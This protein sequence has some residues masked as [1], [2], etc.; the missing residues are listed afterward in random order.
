MASDRRQAAHQHMEALREYASQH[1]TSIE[2][3]YGPYIA[4]SANAPTPLEYFRDIA[5]GH[6]YRYYVDRM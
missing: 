1:S 2:A 3:R 4:K 6:I 5:R